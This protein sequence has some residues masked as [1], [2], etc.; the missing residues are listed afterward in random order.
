MQPFDGPSGFWSYAHQDED[1]ARGRISRLAQRIRDEFSLITGDDLE[2][3]LDRESLAWGDA[4]RLRIDTALQDTTFF[5][6]VITPR[7]F[8]REECRKELMKF[9]THARS[10]GAQ[11]LLLPILYV[12]VPDLN[13]DNP[14]EAVALIA[15]TQYADWRELRLVDEESEAYARAVN[16]LADRLAQVAATYSEQPSLIPGESTER[17]AD[18][19]HDEP[20]ISDLIAD[21]EEAMPK[22][23]ATIEGFPAILQPIQELTT[24]ATQRF[25]SEGQDGFAR[26]VLIAREFAQELD[27]PADALL[28]QG[29]Q[30]ASLLLD[31]DPGVRAMIALADEQTSEDDI[32]TACGMFESL[33]ELIS[34]SEQNEVS[35]REFI[36]SLRGPARQFRD[37]RGP[38]NKLQAGARS[39]IDGQTVMSEW[40]RLMDDSS[41][42]CSPATS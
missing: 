1:Q 13:A 20:G 29:E 38:L 24:N 22:W 40:Q 35:L 21:L 30:Y 36:H 6:P 34:T 16:S 7:Y 12:S 41:L 3:F 23:L 42:Q 15:A 2:L 17:Q 18:G 5:I 39:V 14:D 31:L 25:H 4:W 26:R 10:L 33:R 19:E 32:Q 28:L 37:L 8:K 11:E 9:A 27:E